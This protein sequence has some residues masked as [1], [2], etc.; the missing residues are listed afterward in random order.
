MSDSH[1]MQKLGRP[2]T[3]RELLRLTSKHLRN[4]GTPKEFCA[5]GEFYLELTQ[6][7]K[8]AGR[9]TIPVEEDEEDDVGALVKKLEAKEK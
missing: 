1:E 5:V 8:R 2:V 4:A 6:G 3:K 9:P 7:K